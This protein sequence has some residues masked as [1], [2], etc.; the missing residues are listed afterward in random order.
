VIVVV[1][2]RVA[3]VQA[4]EPVTGGLASALLPVVKDSGA[5]WVGSS[6]R[7]RDAS[8][9][10]PFA[11]I[12]ALG[13]GA[14]ATVVE[15]KPVEI[16]QA[17]ALTVDWSELLADGERWIMVS[18]LPY[19]V[20]TPVLMGALD[21][22]FLSSW[23]RTWVALVA[24]AMASAV[25]LLLLETGDRL[26]DVPLLHN[27]FLRIAAVRAVGVL[28]AF[29]VNRL[30]HRE[31]RA[32]GYFGAEKNLKFPTRMLPLLLVGAGLDIAARVLLPGWVS[33]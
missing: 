1:S 4:N 16:V 31:Y 24:L 30:F 8:G 28:A 20:A 26:V 14:L 10:D 13:T 17:D 18:N 11:E 19:N 25:A 32:L 2:N 6:G 9:K 23:R 22:H 27:D 33:K 15:G 7:V 21:S 5:I 3:R 12:E 29:A